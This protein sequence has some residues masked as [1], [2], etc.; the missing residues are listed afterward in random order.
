MNSLNDNI[1]TASGVEQ[2]KKVRVWALGRG[3]YSKSK[4]YSPPQA[5]HNW[6]PINAFA[7]HL[8]RQMGA[9]D[10]ICT[11][12]GPKRQDFFMGNWNV[13]LLNEKE[14]EMVWESKQ[15]Y[16]NIAG[17]SFTKCRGSDI[18]ELNKGMKLFYSDVDATMSAQA[19]VAFL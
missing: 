13:T 6:K 8:G 15:Y 3:S 2:N 12:V 19:G 11:R 18:V 14:Q 4:L 10:N 16:L 1:V 17:V 9:E 5:D 7:G